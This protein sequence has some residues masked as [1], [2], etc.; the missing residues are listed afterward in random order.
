M[1][2]VL[3]HGGHGTRLR[4]LTHTGPKQLIPV[5]GKPISEYCL[6]DMRNAGVNEV[7]IVLGAMW[8][9]KVREYYGDG[10]RLEMKLH[11]LSQGE[12]KGLAHAIGLARDFVDGEKFVVYLGDNLL[13]GGIIRHV[14]DF[15]SGTAD[16][17]VLLTRV[18][19]PGRFGVAKF[20]KYGKLEALVEKPK[21]APS[22]FA[23]VGVYFFT[24]TVFDIIPRLSPS[25]RDEFEITDA[26]QALLAGRRNVQHRFV[27]GWWKDTGTPE[28]ILEAN[29]LI[30]D[31][32]LVRSEIKGAVEEG[33]VIQGRVRVEKDAIVQSNATIRGP[34]HVGTGT[35]IDAET[36]VGPYTSIGS[37]C[38]LSSC[39]IENSV[40]MDRCRINT[41]Q[42]I[43]DSLIGP[44][45]EILA[46]SDNLPK[47]CHFVL[48]E[49]SKLQL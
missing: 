9:E 6:E 11:Y 24:P 45:C 5:G 12:P 20:D 48:G 31:E 17:I 28:D 38:Q 40:V 16:A 2:G 30:L 18:T 47:A 23:L 34:A 26:I 35:V 21:H 8:P 27:E 19:E 3:L 42:R 41:R 22:P 46:S 14:E 25:F 13:K 1:K 37:D 39:E 7:A 10:S 33:A 49:R 4:P 36:Y 43:T 32:K 29:R 15:E 44:E